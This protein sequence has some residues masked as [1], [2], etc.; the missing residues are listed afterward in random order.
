MKKLIFIFFALVTFCV[1]IATA[2]DYERFESKFTY[3][4]T[5]NLVEYIGTALPGTATTEARWQ[6]QKCV[7][8]ANGNLTDMQFANN[9]N[10]FI[11]IWDNRET[12]T[13]G[14]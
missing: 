4:A 9:S 7:Y 11:F 10:E 13:Y 3:N 14:D 8:N 5:G 12:Y 2:G 1:S 6:I